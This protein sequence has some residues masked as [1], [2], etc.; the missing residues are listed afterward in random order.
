MWIDQAIGIAVIVGLF[1]LL[2]LV[3]LWPGPKHGRRLLTQ[4]GVHEPTETE[5]ATAVRYLKR[6]RFWYPWLYVALSVAFTSTRDTGGNSLPGVLVVLLLGAL[7]AEVLALRPR[8]AARRVAELNRRRATDLVP[9][10]ALVLH[11]LVA[12]SAVV[13]SVAALAG[14]RW[15]RSWFADADPRLPRVV[16]VVAIGSVLVVWLI[17]WLALRRPTEPELRV[18]AALRRRS[19]RV[20]V[21]LGIG[22][23]GSVLAA[24]SGLPAYLVLVGSVV[25]WM[26]VASP[27]ANTPVRAGVG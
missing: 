25:A 26:A 23:V 6:R 20:A 19:A 13:I 9:A 18:D 27:R 14:A 17:V 10:W 15:G 2:I 12:V 3:P 7:V 22:A 5:V 8:R 11:A 1:G 4:W 16:L 24:R 21:G